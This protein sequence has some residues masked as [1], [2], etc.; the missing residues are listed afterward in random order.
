MIGRVKDVLYTQ[1][2]TDILRFV[3]ING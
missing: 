2:D 3:T 1:T